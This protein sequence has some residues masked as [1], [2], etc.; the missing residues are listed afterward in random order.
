VNYLL[1]SKSTRKKIKGATIAQAIFFMF[2]AMLIGLLLSFQ[3]QDVYCRSRLFS[4][5]QI[6]D[7]QWAN[8]PQLQSIVDF[9]IGNKTVLDI[10]YVVHMGDIVNDYDNETDW[11]TKNTAFSQLTNFVPFGWL[12]GDQEGESQWYL[13]DNYYAFNVSNYPNMTSSYDQGRS[14]AQY[15]NFSGTEILFVNL[16]YFANGTA[17]QWFESLYQHYDEAIVIVIISS[18]FCVF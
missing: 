2:A 10:Q 4:F 6:G 14:T 15:F 12:A 3:I 18:S 8:E 9:V 5:V 17:L 7:T 16:E 11:E 13:G 1:F